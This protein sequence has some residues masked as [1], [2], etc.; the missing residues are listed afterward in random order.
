MNLTK[1]VASLAG[2]DTT[3]MR[4]IASSEAV[5]DIYNLNLRKYLF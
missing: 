4:F 1:N 2:C 5:R 3:Y